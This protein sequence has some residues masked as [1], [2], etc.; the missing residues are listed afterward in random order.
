MSQTELTLLCLGV[1]VLAIFGAALRSR[2]NAH[3]KSTVKYHY[4]RKDFMMTRA[5]HEF[6]GILTRR[7]G[8]RYFIFPQVNISAIVSHMVK[9]QDWRAARAHI[10]RLSVDYVVCSKADVRPLV[11]IELDDPTHER[12]DRQ[13]RDTEVNRIFDEVGIPLV[14]FSNTRQMSEADIIQQTTNRLPNA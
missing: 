1:I 8:D 3:Q 13:K 4:K 9:G 5:E 14:R 7:L 6:F 2:D 11:A 10:N 12:E